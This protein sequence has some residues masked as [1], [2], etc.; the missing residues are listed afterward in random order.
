[1]FTSDVLFTCLRARRTS[2]MSCKRVVQ[3]SLCIEQKMGSYDSGN[4][5]FIEYRVRFAF[6]MVQVVHSHTCRS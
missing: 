1:M 2:R 4:A 3:H 5:K 6:Y